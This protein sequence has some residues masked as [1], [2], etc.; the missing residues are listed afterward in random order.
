MTMKIG[1]FYCIVVVHDLLKICINDFYLYVAN[2]DTLEATR[3]NVCIIQLD[4]QF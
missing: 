2:V 3:K 4:F 1:D